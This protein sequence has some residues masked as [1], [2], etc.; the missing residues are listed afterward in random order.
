MHTLL[1]AKH[2]LENSIDN[3]SDFLI[4]QLVFFPLT[5]AGWKQE[6]E[7]QAETED[8]GKNLSHCNTY[9]YSQIHYSWISLRNAAGDVTGALKCIN[10]TQ[11]WR[12]L[13]E[14]EH[15]CVCARV[16]ERGVKAVAVNGEVAFWALYKKIESL[17]DYVVSA[18]NLFF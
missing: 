18:Q 7:Q 16:C 3:T 15:V 9:S 17:E 11:S 6:T 13:S 4:Q 14:V 1:I 2:N 12:R 5:A 10:I 8:R